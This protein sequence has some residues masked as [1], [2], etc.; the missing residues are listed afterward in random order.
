MSNL[1]SM[2]D[3]KVISYLA[4]GRKSFY[5]LNKNEKIEILTDIFE[6]TLEN[7]PQWG[8]EL[9]FWDSNIENI[10]CEFIKELKN[11]QQSPLAQEIINSC[12]YKLNDLIEEKFTDGWLDLDAKMERDLIKA[13]DDREREVA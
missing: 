8:Y 7:D 5:E 4:N 9:M 13:E 2:I 1:L 12:M 10:I 3:N 6:D 11:K